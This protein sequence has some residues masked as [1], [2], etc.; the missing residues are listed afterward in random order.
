MMIEDKSYQML[1]QQLKTKM[2][3]NWVVHGKQYVF[4]KNWLYVPAKFLK[5]QDFKITFKKI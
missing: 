5:S 4:H 1:S 3:A 2:F